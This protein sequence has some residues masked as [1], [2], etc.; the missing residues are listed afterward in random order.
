MSELKVLRTYTTPKGTLLPLI[1][2]KGKEY[3]EVK[4]RLVWFRE[5]HESWGIETDYTYQSDT[6]CRVKAIIR[7]DQG[8]IRAVGHKT[9]SP[10]AT[11]DFDSAETGAIGRA[12]AHCGFGT[13]F[14]TDADEKENTVV[15]SPKEPYPPVDLGFDEPPPIPWEEPKKDAWSGKKSAAEALAQV[16]TSIQ[17]EIGDA[18]KVLPPPNLA[19]YKFDFGKYIGRHLNQVSKEGLQEY[20]EYI[21]NAA[22]KEKKPVSGKGKIALDAIQRYLPSLK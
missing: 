17:K 3:M 9:E 20:S 2:F 13:Q 5:V 1:N 16:A 7:D 4:N 15:D 6:L 19:L 21:Q 12:L 18:A 22:A 8:R 10:S 14:A 11:I